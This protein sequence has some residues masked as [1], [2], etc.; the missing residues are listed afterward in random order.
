MKLSIKVRALLEK[1]QVSK[2]AKGEG[3]IHLFNTLLIGHKKYL[4]EQRISSLPFASKRLQGS[5]RHDLVFIRAPG[6]AR[7]SFVL[8]MDNLWF[9]RV[10]LL[11]QMRLKPTMASRSSIVH[12]LTSWRSAKGARFQVSYE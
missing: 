5:N 9:C 10:L 7:G 12:S 1:L 4:G 3:H 8:R 11:F 6:V 2:A